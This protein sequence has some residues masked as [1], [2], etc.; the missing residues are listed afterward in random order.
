[1]IIFPD[2]LINTLGPKHT[3]TISETA[4]SNAGSALKI[5]ITIKFLL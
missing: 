5:W 4:F 2:P 3:A 1:M